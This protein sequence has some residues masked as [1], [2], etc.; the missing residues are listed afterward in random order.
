MQA[1]QHA[2]TFN[3]A[4]KKQAGFDLQIE[5][6]KCLNRKEGFYTEGFKKA[7]RIHR[8]GG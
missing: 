4:F 2:N 3:H 7:R 8:C 1:F 6:G 5:C